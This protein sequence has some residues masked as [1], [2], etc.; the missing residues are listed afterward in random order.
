MNRIKTWL[1]RNKHIR[2]LNEVISRNKYSSW[3]KNLLFNN[4]YWMLVCWFLGAQVIC[5]AIELMQYGNLEETK[6]FFLNNTEIIRINILI[7]MAVTSV[8]FLFKR[9][10]FVYTILGFI[11]LGLGMSN[12]I[13]LHTKG[14]PLTYFDIF[15]LKEAIEVSGQYI[16]KTMVISIILIFIIAISILFIVWKVMKKQQFFSGWIVYL[17]IFIVLLSTPMSIK[18]ARDNGIIED[19]FWDIISSYKANGFSY[20]FLSTIEASK[21]KTPDN[22]NENKVLELKEKVQQ[23]EQINSIEDLDADVIMIQLESFFD[24]LLLEGI[25]YNIDP[26][27]TF[28]E[29]SDKYTSGISKVPT[30][31]GGT[32]KSEFE[33]LTGMSI[34][35]FS[36]GEIPYNT[37]LRKQAVESMPSILKKYGL[38]AHALHNF[39][40]TFYGRDE[41]YK[42]LGFDTFTPIEYMSGFAGT[43][44]GWPK[45]EGLLDYIDAA[46]NSTTENDFIYV[47]TAQGHG[48]YDYGDEYDKVIEVDGEI[49]END[50][51]Q[52]EYYCN[53]LYE[54]DQFIKSLIEYLEKRDKPTIV[55]FISDHLPSLNILNNESYNLEKYQVD[56]FIWDNIGL[57]KSDEDIE[58]YQL[59]TKILNLLNVSDSIMQNI[60]N[61]FKNDADYVDSLNIL[62]YDILFGKHY[63]LEGQYPF[64][65]VNTKL[66][67]RNIS[68][69]DKYI[70]NGD[71]IIKGENFTGSSR[72]FVKNKMY[73][74]VLIDNTEL[75]VLGFDDDIN[76]VSV[77][78][79]AGQAG[80]N[81]KILGNRE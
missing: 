76:L 10:Y 66:G 37:I 62:Q 23:Q 75:Q 50:K 19:R 69:K 20:S 70:K 36:P 26:I 60:H 40:G 55:S 45:D 18:A 28:R 39:E 4:D 2:N 57:E 77:N 12:R 32:V 15:L 41:V 34:D 22:Y 21:R 73:D 58:A 68:V 59:S 64:E 17:M 56:Y 52:L 31:G 24:P 29:M 54:T 44:L 71:L 30:F 51:R 14:E 27:S 33:F 65:K 48:G 53:Q 46:L 67:I 1:L 81:N 7:I 11:L 38:K 63:Y 6:N 8:S 25:S 80:R 72:V 3:I 79:V 49:D 5:F 47:V 61:T 74:T 16:D 78:Q 42:N 43:P 13:L 35:C 9:K